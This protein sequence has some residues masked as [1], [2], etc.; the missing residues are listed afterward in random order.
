VAGGSLTVAVQSEGF[1]H[2][3]R[4][5]LADEVR[6]LGAG[7]EW[8]VPLDRDGRIVSSGARRST[9]AVTAGTTAATTASTTAG[10]D[11]AHDG[12]GGHDHGG[13]GA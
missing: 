2:P 3:V 10:P 5:G 9:E 1:S 13:N 8:T 7:Q 6:E 12:S 11:G 4:I